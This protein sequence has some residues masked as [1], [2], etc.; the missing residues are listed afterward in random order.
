MK[1][2]RTVLCPTD[3]SDACDGARVLAADVAAAMG[4]HLILHH[5]L[6]GPAPGLGKSWEWE[7][8]GF[9]DH[10]SAAR[11]AMEDALASVP[12]GLS[13]EA[14]L[15]RGPLFLVLRHLVAETSADLVVLAC[16]GVSSED[17]ASLTERFV[18]QSPCPVLAVGE[19]VQRAWKT[20]LSTSGEHTGPPLR[21]LVA[22][23]LTEE[24]RRAVT[25]AFDLA[26]RLPIAI[27]LVHVLPVDFRS[28][29]QRRAEET[30]RARS[31]LTELVPLDLLD[32]TSVRIVRGS[33]RERLPE[34]GRELHTDLMIV[35]EHA[36]SLLRR[37]FT[38]DTAQAL[39]HRAECPVWMVPVHAA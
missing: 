22:T 17:H 5:N 32:R 25:Y 33:P 26:R 3:F 21:V 15:T 18:R 39:I 2:I 31:R 23:D 7:R 34:L 16:H 29:A 8:E 13:T 11:S 4:A 9:D 24:S 1:Q 12:T 14:R 35:G 28:P 20:V 10:E 38:A 37:L 30:A 27:E 6:S 36:P 19:T